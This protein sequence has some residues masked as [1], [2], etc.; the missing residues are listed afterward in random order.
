MRGVDRADTNGLYVRLISDG[1][2]YQAVV[3]FV[4]FAL[5]SPQSKQK[6]AFDA[7]HA[8]YRAPFAQLFFHVV[9]PM[10]V[11]LVEVES[12][13]DHGGSTHLARRPARTAD[14]AQP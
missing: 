7:A 13:K 14:I 12:A 2:V 6:Q 3:D 5:R 8:D 10:P 9:A 4:D 11:D 1:G